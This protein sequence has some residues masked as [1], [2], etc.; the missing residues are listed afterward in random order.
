MTIE[1]VKQVVAY[2]A[3]DDE[4]Y[5]H[6]V[7]GEDKTREALQQNYPGISEQDISAIFAAASFAGLAISKSDIFVSEIESYLQAEYG[8]Q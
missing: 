1:A 5:G 4:F 3:Q 2:A 8:R 7:E 6:L